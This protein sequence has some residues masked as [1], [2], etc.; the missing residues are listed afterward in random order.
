M[1]SL[2]FL[3]QVQL[4][5]PCFYSRDGLSA[6]VS[7]VYEVGKFLQF[8][9]FGQLCEPGVAQ[10]SSKKGSQGLWLFTNINAGEVGRQAVLAPPAR[11]LPEPN[12]S[13]SSP[14]LARSACCKIA[15]GMLSGVVN[16]SVC[17]CL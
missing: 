15:L 10:L 7:V 11:R 8:Y 3:C 4:V 5:P 14:F 1:A 17:I 6:I 2:P 9:M 12:L 16:N 13:A